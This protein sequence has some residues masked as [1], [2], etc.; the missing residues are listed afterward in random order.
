MLAVYLNAFTHAFNPVIDVVIRA[1]SHILVPMFAV[2]MAGS[3]LV[4][5]ITFGHD[6]LDFF[7]DE[8]END[9]PTADN[10]TPS[11]RPAK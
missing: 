9:M 11:V 3:A 5:V 7:S 8:G 2:G 1:L 4:V 10:M 6:L